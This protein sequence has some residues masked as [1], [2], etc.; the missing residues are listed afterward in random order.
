[1]VSQTFLVNMTPSKK[2]GFKISF[3][4]RFLCKIHKNHLIRP[5][6]ESV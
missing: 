5:V 1:M 3:L 6:F 4:R 2:Q